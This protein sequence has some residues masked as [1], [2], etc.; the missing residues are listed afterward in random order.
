[1]KT[2]KYVIALFVLLNTFTLTS[3]TSNDTEEDQLTITTQDT[4]A[5]GEDSA[6]PAGRD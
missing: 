5:T 6:L 1:M 2:F 3:C 4:F